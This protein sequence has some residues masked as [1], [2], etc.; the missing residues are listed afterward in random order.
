M[1]VEEERMPSW[2]I[3]A[4]ALVWLLAFFWLVMYL[5]ETYCTT[6]MCD[7]IGCEC[8]PGWADQWTPPRGAAPP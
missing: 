2:A 8:W 5:K 6:I 7:Y 4:V 1:Y 3:K